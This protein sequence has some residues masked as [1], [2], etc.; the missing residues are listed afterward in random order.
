MS[1]RREHERARCPAPP[2][3]ITAD[4]LIPMPLRGYLTALLLGATGACIFYA[5]KLPLPWFLGALTA[6]LIGSVANLP[7]VRP[8]PLS[9]PMRA[10]LGVAVGSAYTPALLGRLGGMASSLALMV[11]FMMLVIGMGM[12]FYERIGKFDRP[13]AFYSAV[14]GGLTD[15]TTM[16]EDSGANVRAVILVQASR[17]LVIVFAL[18]LWLQW[19]DGLAVGQAF[20]TRVRLG[21]IWP[22]D[23]LVMVG[24]GWSGWW[25]ASRLGLAGAPIVGP[26]LVSGTAHAFGFTL[27]KV[28]LEVLIIAQISVGTMLGCQFRGLTLKEFT[29]TMTWGIA[30]ALFLL[31]VTGF[32]ASGVSGLTGF[33]PVSVL[34]AFAPGGQTELNLLAYV[35]GLDVAYVALHHLMR[36]AIV[37]LGAQLVFRTKTDWRRG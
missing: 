12:A 30:Y 15:M 7:V 19:H 20:A 31:V 5:L 2:R 36:L 29:G 34:L 10:V 6:C 37:I 8:K 22:F 4:E 25:A 32:V 33:D 28:P 26:M 24:M 11:P 27:A 9:I 3:P 23:A 17:I 35:L 18:P 13:T 1:D 14:P 21:D 16:A